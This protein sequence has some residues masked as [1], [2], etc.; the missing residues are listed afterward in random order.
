MCVR[1]CF[2]QGVS[3]QISWHAMCALYISPPPPNIP[4]VLKLVYT[5]DMT[6]LGGDKLSVASQLAAA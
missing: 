2:K 4:P 6:E 5:H 1:T 3:P